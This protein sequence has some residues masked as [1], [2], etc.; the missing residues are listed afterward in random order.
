MLN[1]GALIDAGDY[2]VW[3]LNVVSSKAKSL[4]LTF[5]S[6][7][8]PEGAEVFVFSQ[9]KTILFGPLAPG[10]FIDG[11]EISTEVLPGN[12]LYAIY[13]VPKPIEALNDIVISRI[14]Y[15]YRDGGSAF[16]SSGAVHERFALPCHADV[17]GSDGDC[18][19]VHQRAVAK[20][21]LNNA[22]AVC[23]GTLIN[24]TNA[25][26]DLRA[27]LLTAN[28]CS[29]DRQGNPV[30][31]ANIGIRFLDFTGSSGVITFIGATE[32]VAT[33]AISDCS[34][35]ELDRRPSAALGLFHLGWDRS[36]APPMASR[37]LH[38]PAGLPMKISGDADAS[39]A[40]PAPLAFGR[41]H[42]PIG[43]AWRFNSGDNIAAGDFG[44]IEGGSSGSA[45]IDL[46]SNRIVGNL[47]GG[48]DQACIG[49][50]GSSADK[51][52]GRFDISYSPPGVPVANAGLR[53][54]NWLN[55]SFNNV[56][57]L[58]ATF[59]LAGAG[60]IIPC[61]QLRQELH[62]PFLT[63]DT[64]GAYTYVWRSSPSI[65]VSGAGSSVLFYAN[66]SCSNC[67]AWVE[68]D[69]RTP[70]SCGN[71]LV[72]RSIRRNF[73][74]GTTDDAAFK[75]HIT[76][77]T[78]NNGNILG[79]YNNICA[80]G[81]YTITTGLTG[82]P[83]PSYIQLQ[84]SV[85]S[86]PVT[87]YPGPQ[88]CGFTTN[89]AGFAI[90]SCTVLNGQGCLSGYSET[91]VFEIVHPCTANFTYPGWTGSG[92]TADGARLAH[93]DSPP[94]V[95]IYPNP[96]HS[97]STLVLPE[98]FDEES[99][100]VDIYDLNGVLM[101][102]LYAPARTTEIDVSRFKNG[103]FVVSASDKSTTVTEKLIISR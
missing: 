34:L 1:Y 79:A 96:A 25:H 21:L 82:I 102:R 43:R 26:N 56:Q 89:G 37:V 61:P 6:L 50:N 16:A 14:G 13:R 62:A 95:Q 20:T 18:F 15:G 8:M 60:E 19:R 10:M 100:R 69:I 83:L 54:E 28:H 52:Y 92:Q 76:P 67:P 72:A 17:A 71:R 57:N 98:S 46:A 77:A 27:F 68:C 78:N 29:F 53:L 64:E 103:L 74:W 5:D 36:T 85:I 4:S 93:R 40:N 58:G 39:V 81:T 3:V 75:Q 87:L 101:M 42:L 94:R 24:N 70:A 12:S 47:K 35:L 31:F 11:S 59:Q 45:L 22:T 80:F 90:I 99:G 51:W 38:H 66:G 44:A 97:K 2:W 88:G 49:G 7:Q 73:A 30:N 23:T 63:S 84:W 86:G 41:F 65:T 55:P 91:Y 9:E 33:G 32:R 48:A